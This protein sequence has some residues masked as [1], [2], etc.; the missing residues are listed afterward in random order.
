MDPKPPQ[1]PAAD[2]ASSLDEIIS[3][4]KAK[5]AE[6]RAR[7]VDPY[8]ARAARRIPLTSRL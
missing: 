2:A 4:K 8:P 1:A 7:G 6:L 3:G 5:L